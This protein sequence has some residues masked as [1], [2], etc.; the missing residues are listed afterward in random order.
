MSD[1]SGWSTL[2][3]N[4]IANILSFCLPFECI[5]TCK[6]DPRRLLPNVIRTKTPAITQ[7][8]GPAILNRLLY[9][10]LK[11]VIDRSNI[12]AARSFI[13]DVLREL[14]SEWLDYNSDGG[15]QDEERMDTEVDD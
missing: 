2:P 3:D 7:D 11:R 1:L 4:V 10:N 15:E 9:A 8:T 12:C 6:A 13:L 5:N 14:P